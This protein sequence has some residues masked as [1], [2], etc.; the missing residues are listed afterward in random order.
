MRFITVSL[1]FF[2]F[3]PRLPSEAGE[4]AALKAEKE[5]SATKPPVGLVLRVH[6]TKVKTGDYLWFQLALNN[7]D[8]KDTIP[9]EAVFN[10]PREMGTQMRCRCGLYLEIIDS[11]RKTMPVSIPWAPMEGSAS[12]TAEDDAVAREMDAFMALPENQGLSPEE[13]DRR[14]TAFVNRSRPV[15]SDEEKLVWPGKSVQTGAWYP[16][17]YRAKKAGKPRPGRVGDFA[18]L[19]FVEFKKP[20]RYKV[21]AAYDWTPEKGKPKQFRWQVRTQTPWIDLQVV[22]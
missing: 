10:D 4:V 18:E 7:L 8:D 21:R 14:L 11:D 5:V 12:S 2:F 19:P 22:P 15:R 1:A 6:K 13:R 16:Y 17:T 20:G 9:R 3:L